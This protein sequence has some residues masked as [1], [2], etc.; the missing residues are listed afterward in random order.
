[1][2]SSKYVDTGLETI[3]AENPWGEMARK[4]RTAL[5]EKSLGQERF[6]LEEDNAIISVMESYVRDDDYKLRLNLPPQPFIGHPSAKIWILQYNP[7]YSY[8]IDDFDYHGVTFPELASKMQRTTSTLDERIKLVCDQYE[9]KGGVGFYA[10][11]EVFR[12]FNHGTRNGKGMYLWYHSTFFPRQ[13]LFSCIGDCVANQKRFA[14]NNLFVIEYLPYHSRKFRHEFF[15]FLPSFT[16][17]R[18]LMGYAL[19]HEKILL[20]NGLS[21]RNSLKACALQSLPGYQEAE[22]NGLIW[23]VSQNG[24]GRSRLMLKHDL[25][26]PLGGERT[27]L[28]DFLASVNHVP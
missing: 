27:H 7:G 9:F 28:D 15:P 22:S 25:V 20:C 11:N 17:W 23:S 18:K 1:M 16:F 6:V 10:L 5:N 19:T 21:D 24:R 3:L 26:N 2:L 14:D 12:T 13:G 4:V 8:G